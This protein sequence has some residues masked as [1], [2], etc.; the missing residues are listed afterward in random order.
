MTVL[1]AFALIAIVTPISRLGLPDFEL[2][3]HDT[4]IHLDA[5][6]TI[7]LITLVVFASVFMFLIVEVVAGRYRIVG[8]LIAIIN[9]IAAIFVCMAISTLSDTRDTFSSMYPSLSFGWYTTAMVVFS[10]ILFFQVIIEV[11]ALKK[12]LGLLHNA[13]ASGRGSAGRA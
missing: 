11:R 8:L 7:F 12:F 9:P 3:L 5:G 1:G 4:Y 2:Q 6:T 10:C 13:R